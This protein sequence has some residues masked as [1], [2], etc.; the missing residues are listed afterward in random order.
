[1]LVTGGCGFIGSNFIRLLLTTRPDWQLVNLDK[2]TYA[3]NPANLAD[4]ASSP[5]YR[6]VQGDIC[7]AD[8]VNQVASGTDA[9]VHFA[10]ESHVD[11]SIISSQEFVRTNVLG[12]QVL[13]AAALRHGIGRFV[14]VSTD[15]VYGSLGSEGRFTESTPLN[16]RSPYAASKAAG[17]LL[18]QAYFATHSLPVC[19]VRPSNNYGPYQYP[20]KFIP[21]MITNLI[22]GL[23]V[24]VYGRGANVRDWLYVED[25]CRAVQLVLEA[26]VAGAVYNIGGGNELSNIDLARRVVSL[27]G[28]GDSEIEFVPDRPG[29]DFR[30]AL[31][32]DR[33]ARELGW[34]PQVA[35]SDGLAR[36]VQWYVANSDWWRPLKSRLDREKHGFWSR[37]EDRLVDS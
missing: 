7:D 5:H 27:M 12:T 11:R 4:L 37:R 2:L 23:K 22:E 33:V 30:Y 10:A 17:D 8:V 19:I 6:F 1:M 34:T 21:L 20:E 29:H 28:K 32:S 35:I 31:A 9:I 3:G 13:L 36:T 16:P 15:E 14:Y 24:P 25:C 26:G 18:A